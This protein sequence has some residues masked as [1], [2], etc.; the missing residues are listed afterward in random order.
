MRMFH[1][2][3]ET[4]ATRQRTS[5]EPTSRNG[6]SSF[7]LIWDLP[8]TPLLECSA[9]L[10]VV[11]PPQVPRLYFWALQASFASGSRFHGGAHIGLQWNTRHPGGTAAR[12]GPP[13]ADA[14]GRRARRPKLHTLALQ[15]ATAPR[16]RPPP[17]P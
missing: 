5:G 14:P 15:A 7:H 6:A 9:V 1:R 16:P 8:P 13:V 2:A 17:P 4:W 10:E 3:R 12:R 11:V